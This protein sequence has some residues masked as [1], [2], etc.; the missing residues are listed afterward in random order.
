MPALFQ[1]RIHALQQYCRYSI[2]DAAQRGGKPGGKPMTKIPQKHRLAFAFAAP[3][4]VLFGYK[5]FQTLS[6]ATPCLTSGVAVS[7]DQSTV[8]ARR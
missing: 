6:T 5:C 7:A 3:G 8:P 2:A 4:A 1:R